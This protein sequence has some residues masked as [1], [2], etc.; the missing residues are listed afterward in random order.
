MI[1]KPKILFVVDKWCAGNIHWG[2]S[3]WEG[4][5]WQSLQAV[6]LA[7]VEVF[8]FDEYYRINGIKGD[9]A[10]LKK[11]SEFQPQLICLVIYNLPDTVNT[12]SLKTLETIKKCFSIPIFAIWGDFEY[13]EQVKISDVFQ[14]F[15]D[16]NMFTATSVVFR[17]WQNMKKDTKK[18]SYSWVPKDPRYFYNPNRPRDLNISYPGSTKPER[19]RKIRYLER[20]GLKVYR[21]G[22]E[23]EEHLT[24][25]E[26]GEIFQRSKIILSFSQAGYLPVTNARTFEATNCGAML[27]EEASPE[28]AKLFIPYVDYVPYF[29]KKD[30]LKKARYYLQN[31]TER[32]KIAN[33]GYLKTQQYYSAYRFWKIVLAKADEVISVRSDDKIFDRTHPYQLDQA[34]DQLILADWGRKTIELPWPRL[35]KLSFFQAITLKITDWFCSYKL[36]YFFYLWHKRISDWHWLLFNFSYDC[37]KVAR[38]IFPKR[39]GDRLKVSLKPYLKLMMKEL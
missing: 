32:L 35:R 36:P 16:F 23:H 22:G 27:L 10:I 17:R 18:F 34:D 31:E 15:I 39:I 14:P 33:S 29:S 13:E 21:T 24:T 26:F 19:L 1:N 7:E 3:A 2:L 11:V 28:T 25:R 9:E 12:P 4:N 38:F 8:H 30:L 6:N 20:H 5:L 37:F